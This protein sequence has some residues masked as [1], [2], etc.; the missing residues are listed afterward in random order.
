[1]KKGGVYFL[2]GKVKNI[3][4]IECLK[5]HG[6]VIIRDIDPVVVERK[7]QAFYKDLHL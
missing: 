2:T 5:C 3:F 4:R 1:M 6:S 7:S